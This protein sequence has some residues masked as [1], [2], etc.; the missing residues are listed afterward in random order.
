VVTP[1]ED[2]LLQTFLQSRKAMETRDVTDKSGVT[3]ASR[4]IRRLRK[5]YGG[6]FADA[7]RTPAG[8]KKGAGGSFISVRNL[9]S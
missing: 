7:I 1:E 9:N 3:N 4:V 8:G 5:G 2:N 6:M